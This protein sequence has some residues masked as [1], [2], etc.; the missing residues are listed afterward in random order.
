MK[1][2]KLKKRYFLL[3][4]PIITILIGII[5]IAT[6]TEPKLEGTY[7]LTVEN[8]RTHTGSL[9]KSVKIIIKEN[10][11]YYSRNGVI[12]ELDLNQ[13]KQT[14]V[15]DGKTYYYGH[16]KGQLDLTEKLREE[17]QYSYVTYVSKESSMYEAYEKGQV[18]IS[19]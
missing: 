15:I 12:E 11:A 1:K 16:V 3:L 14:L 5:G 18:K 19:R 8:P 4:I 10:R 9:D 13:E 2:I 17:N 6:Y 7:Y